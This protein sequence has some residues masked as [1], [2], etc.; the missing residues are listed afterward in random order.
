[1]KSRST[2][3]DDC[4]SARAS[5]QELSDDVKNFDARVQKRIQELRLEI[6]QAKQQEESL[7][8]G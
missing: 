5:L 1:M 4:S 6:T 7:A 3:V 2:V 8:T